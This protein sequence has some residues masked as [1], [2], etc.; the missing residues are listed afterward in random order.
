[1]TDI[2][3]D[4][5]DKA[6]NSLMN[7][8]QQQDAA[9]QPSISAAS[10]APVISESAP[11]SAPEMLSPPSSVAQ[12][13]TPS[14]QAVVPRRT[15]RFMDVV[16][17]SSQMV[18]R[19]TSPAPSRT[20]ASLQPVS[21]DVM[22]E[23][24]PEPAITALDNQPQSAA[25][26]QPADDTAIMA[27]KIEES[28]AASAHQ[29]ESADTAPVFTPAEPVPDAA[30]ASPFIE[31]PVVEKRPLGAPSPFMTTDQSSVDSD[32]TADTSPDN[33]MAEQSALAPEFDQALMALESATVEPVVT[34]S[35]DEQSPID[36]VSTESAVDA[37][38][39]TSDVVAAADQSGS[40]DAVASSAA[41]GM[42]TSVAFD[43]SVVAAETVPEPLPMFDAASQQPPQP[44]KKSTMST[45]LIII[46]LLLLG[47]GGGAAAYYV[48]LLQ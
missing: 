41:P 6:V 31:N 48:M 23:A 1:M 43:T 28:L 17:P 24:V 26:S 30:L 37:P 19:S 9:P 12:E 10:P 32:V 15:G 29:R 16:H 7:Q 21:Q 27:Q 36:A 14:P 8:R 18:H 46:L 40:S 44:A 39:T 5:L 34:S 25:V 11:S 13:P 22:P 20:G 2:D 4:E 38:M 45:L 3:F 42:L 35:A 47:A 33:D